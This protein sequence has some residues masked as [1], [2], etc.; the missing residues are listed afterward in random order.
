MSEFTRGNWILNPLTA[1]INALTINARGTAKTPVAYVYGATTLNSPEETAEP[2]ANARLIKN[3]PYMFVL[4]DHIANKLRETNENDNLLKI[5]KHGA[6]KMTSNLSVRE[7]ELISA[8][9][10]AANE[11]FRCA[12]GYTRNAVNEAYRI[13][14]LIR[15]I[16]SK[17][18][19]S[20]AN[21]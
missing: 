12:G 2:L 15:R 14:D 20:R 7:K 3:A 19:R 4:L 17:T 10:L 11:L 6:T 13:R 8:L 18:E 1:M 21:D 16:D 9:T 5:K